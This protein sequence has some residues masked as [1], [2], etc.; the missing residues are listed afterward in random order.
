MTT[1]WDDGA[2]ISATTEVR[3][4]EYGEKVAV[5]EPGGAEFIP[6]Q[7][8]HGRPGG[9]FWTWMSPNFEF[10]TVFVGV[11]AVAGFGETLGQS[12]AAIVL[13]SVLGSVTMGALS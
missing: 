3:V 12:V 5:I 11:L 7:E 10:A 4:G 6:L 2:A 9:L 1:V 8:R 13:G